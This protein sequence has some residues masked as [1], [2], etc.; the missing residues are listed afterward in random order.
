MS[1]ESL[2]VKF[3]LGNSFKAGWVISLNRPFYLLYCCSLGVRP[4]FVVRLRAF[5]REI[6]GG[7]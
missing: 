4:F 1:C 7:R 2:A 6:P 3:D 5:L